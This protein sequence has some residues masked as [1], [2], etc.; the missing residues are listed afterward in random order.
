M[1]PREPRQ[2]RSRGLVAAVI[3]AME[4]LV[5]AN[6]TRHVSV[7]ALARR[8]GVSAGSIYDYFGN[9]DSVVKRIVELATGTNAA[10]MEQVLGEAGSPEALLE[11]S[12]DRALELFFAEP[13]RSCGLITAALRFD[14]YALLVRSRH[15]FARAFAG[16][17]VDLGAH[18]PVPTLE[19]AAMLAADASMGVF[20]TCGRPTATGR[21]SEHTCY[22]WRG[23][24][25]R[26]ASRTCSGRRLVTARR[27]R[28]PPAAG[29]R[30]S[31]TAALRS[32]RPRCRP[33]RA[34]RRA[35][36]PPVRATGSPR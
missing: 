1:S 5:T 10:S 25:L 7:Q 22:G 36:R 18:S 8:A 6:G 28:T 11:S 29:G 34:A 35:S 27:R 4:Q 24:S 31:P 16:R 12:V 13:A 3:E 23:P 26:R 14:R 21:S 17:L 30:G 9:V 15:Q 33:A 19:E 20:D 2:G 32:P